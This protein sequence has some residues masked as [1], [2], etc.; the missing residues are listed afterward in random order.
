MEGGRKQEHYCS[1]LQNVLSFGLGE[2]GGDGRF[3]KGEHL[4]PVGG[5]N[6]D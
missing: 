2:E 5:S 3:I 4:V 1:E 6:R